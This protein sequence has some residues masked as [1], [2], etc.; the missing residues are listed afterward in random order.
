MCGDEAMAVRLT[1]VA[2]AS[3]REANVRGV[4]LGGWAGMTRQRL[5][6]V[7]DQVGCR[8]PPKKDE[9]HLP[10]VFLVG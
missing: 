5:D 7:A 10:P 2:L 4:L 9:V 1:R 6:P 8:S 3:L